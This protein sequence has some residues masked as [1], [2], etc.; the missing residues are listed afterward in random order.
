MTDDPNSSL[1]KNRREEG[2]HKQGVEKGG[3]TDGKKAVVVK[4]DEACD[5]SYLWPRLRLHS[6]NEIL[7]RVEFYL[8]AGRSRKGT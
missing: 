5:C 3:I 6:S 8:K 2:S 4:L 1:G 7:S